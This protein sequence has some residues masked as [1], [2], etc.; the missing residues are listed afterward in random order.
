MTAAA[1]PSPEHRIRPFLAAT[2]GFDPDP[3]EIRILHAD[4]PGLA[5]STLK[6][7][8]PCPSGEPGFLLLSGPGNPDLVARAVR[9]I[10]AVRSRLPEPLAAT[11]LAPVLTGEID[12]RSCAVWPRHLPFVVPGRLRFR[13]RALW[14]RARLL[15]WA[16]DLCAATL[17]EP[18]GAEARRQGFGAPLARLTADAGF[19]DDLR[20]RAEAALARLE[21]GAWQPRHCIQHGDL[22]AGNFLLPRPGTPPVPLYVID[23]AG[24]RLTGYPVFD[25]ARLGL[26]LRCP[27]RR[28]AT[29]LAGLAGVLGCEVTDIPAYALC[30]IGDLGATLEHFPEARYRQMAQQVTAYLE[31][32]TT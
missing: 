29:H 2:G 31:A 8:V 28:M 6:C 9:N 1:E 21:T 5:D 25:S 23:W 30:A 3:D 16:R 12:G 26:S 27:P 11:V 18:A 7:L 17:S 10:G 20:R 15:G 19:P 32:A 13:L 4:R 14:Y 24:A 22:W